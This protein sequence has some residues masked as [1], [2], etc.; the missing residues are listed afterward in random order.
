MSQNRID[1][2]RILSEEL[3]RTPAAIKKELPLPAESEAFIL[4]AR[5]E[6]CNI[7]E[8]K[9]HRLF[10]LVGPCS[11]H[12]VDSAFEYA[13][14]LKQVADAAS[15]TLLVVMRVYFE[16]PR[17]TVGWKGL[18]NDPLLDGSFQIDEGMKRARG[19]L[20]KIA[21]LGLPTGT[22]ALDPVVPQYLGELAT[23]TAIGARTTGSQTHRE[24][25]SGLSTP[26]GFKNGTDGN[27]RVAIDAIKAVS[28]PHH[29]LGISQEGQ[30]A[31]FRTSGNRHTHIVL[32]GGDRPNY[33]AEH[34]AEC[35]E[36]L[37]SASLPLNIVVDCS[38]GNSGKNPERQ[39]DVL[40][41]C[42]SQIAAGNKSIVGF[43]LESNIEKGNQE[44]ITGGTPL[45]DGVSI[46]DA[47]LD[48]D[49]TE[50]VLRSMHDDLVKVLP[51]RN[52]AQK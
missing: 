34:I 47:C 12:D 25:A 21:E 23:W 33:D 37:R 10:A 39:P 41:D 30:G 35:E 40:R 4:R 13:K 36:E 17:T 15:D 51:A 44:I 42:V 26:V 49:A 43:M 48:W 2:V 9:D 11:I 50:R 5:E 6:L 18:I 32:R 31:V 22:E 14:R 46:T 8:G 45:K 27:M 28:S 16:K 3:L 24:M 7:L 38:H 20:L 1:N 52:R 29:F 19:L